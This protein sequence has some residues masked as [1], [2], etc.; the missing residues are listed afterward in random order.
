MGGPARPAE[1]RGN[2]GTPLTADRLAEI[3]E[4]ARCEGYERGLAEG[5]ADGEAGLRKQAERLSRLLDSLDP[6]CGVL[7]EAL[8]DQVASLVFAVAR[9]F[10][11]RELGQAPGEIV[12][13]VR[14]AMTV[15]PASNTTARILLHPDDAALVREV[16]APDRTSRPVQIIEDVTIT[17]GGARIETEVSMVDATVESRLNAIAARLL[18]NA[19]T[20]DVAVTGE[21]P[22]A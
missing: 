5:R 1:Q 19:R 15:L 10:V 6:Q 11:R 14:E 2:A 21:Q 17:A 9:Q 20:T 8:F 4:Q 3:E 12:R 22:D 13:V 7:D 18:G 16:L